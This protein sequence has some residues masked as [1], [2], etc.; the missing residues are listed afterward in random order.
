MISL[1]SASVS[2]F[3]E[4]LFKDEIY[5][6][7]FPIRLCQ[8]GCTLF[9][10]FPNGYEKE[11]WHRALMSATDVMPR[12]RTLNYALYSQRLAQDCQK[13]TEENAWLNAI[14][15][16]MLN[17]MRE[18]SE[19]QD[20]VFARFQRTLPTLALPS[21]IKD[22]MLE[23]FDLGAYGFP[24]ISKARLHSLS[25]SG[26][27]LASMQV[28]YSDGVGIQASCRINPDVTGLSS[29]YWLD[30]SLSIR[31][32]RLS[33]RVQVRSKGPFSDRIW[34]AFEEPPELQFE[35]E[36]ALA[37]RPIKWGLI[38]SLISRVIETAL[39]DVVV[40]PNMIDAIIPPLQVG[41][42]SM[43]APAYP[44]RPEPVTLAASLSGMGS[45]QSSMATLSEHIV[46]RT[47]S[48]ADLRLIIQEVQ[49]DGKPRKRGLG[50]MAASF[51]GL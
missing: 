22:V 1:A 2:I 16:T 8:N 25:P 48:E 38:E 40:L 28:N 36:P 47:R 45:R 15:G 9:L 23:K 35:I 27:L 26:E 46:S 42:T 10:Y 6:K 12:P 29:S 17:R 31:V 19:L 34:I 51:G 49:Q 5:G 3:P 37:T 43:H 44:G 30:T 50:A 21:L 32:K 11:D 13:K 14:I 7:E 20:V 4:D 24:H 39:R 33:G 41:G 18:S